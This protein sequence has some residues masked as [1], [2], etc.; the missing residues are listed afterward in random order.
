[1]KERRILMKMR[2]LVLMVRYKE[3]GTVEDCWGVV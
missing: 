2:E 3:G 1:V